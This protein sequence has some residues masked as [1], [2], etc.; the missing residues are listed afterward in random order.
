MLRQARRPSAGVRAAMAAAAVLAV[1]ALVLPAARPRAQ[2]GVSDNAK[3]SMQHQAFRP[4][5]VFDHPLAAGHSA[6]VRGRVAADHVVVQFERGMTAREIRTLVRDAGGVGVER[7]TSADF[8]V[9]RLP[10]GQDPVAMAA[11][12]AGQPG[13][14]YAEPDPIVH[15]LYKPNDPLY[16][17]QWH[18]QKI[19]M[20]AA[21]DLNRG[22][23][24]KTTVAVLD[25]G[26]AYVNNGAFAQAPDLAGT[27]FVAGYDFIWNDT[28]PE[29]T[30]GHGTHVTGTIAQTSN[31]G[32]GVAGI[33]FNVNIMPVKVLASDFDA[34]NHAPNDSTM[35]ILAQGIRFAAD[36]GAQVI[37]MSLGA[38]GPSTAVEDA[39]RYAVG[40]GVF[41][42][43]AAGNGGD[44]DNA[45]EW[46]AA[47]APGIEGLVAVA[48]VDYN[49]ARAPYS[50]HRDYVEIAAPGGNVDADLNNDGYGDG[51]LQQTFD[52]TFSDKDIFN[53]FAY[54][55]YEGTSMATAHVSGIAALLY[56]QGITSPGAIEAALKQTAQKK[57]AAGRDNDVGSGVVDPR[58]ALR[59]FGL[60]K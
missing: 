15:P 53:R 13:V 33:A 17:F 24:T 5:V 44:T 4:A 25:T 45:A 9:V 34:R 11:R 26:V 19:G 14:V 30:D 21:W 18:L 2:S 10:A 35:S 27:H 47:Y 59:G 58:A 51:V 36:H 39:I 16:S 50:T 40:K 60:A 22:G 52:P 37:N 43:V 31:N 42:A 46:P 7:R 54:M 29:D 3:Q 28:V 57:P 8:H 41:L 32:V 55:F 20:E 48:A 56:D 38:D 23:S 12:L 1:V 49:L 6:V